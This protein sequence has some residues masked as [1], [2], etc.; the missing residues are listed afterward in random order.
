MALALP[1][2]H[3]THAGIWLAS[4]GGTE[5]ISVR[6]ASRGEAIARAAETPHIILNA[7][8]VGS[9]LGYPELWGLDLL[10]L[11]AFIHP[12]SFVV[13]T[14][15]GLRRA[16]GLG[17][18]ASEPTRP[19]LFQRDR[20][21]ACWRYSPTRLARTRRR[22]DERCDARTGC[23]WRWAPLLARAPRAAGARRAD[24]CSRA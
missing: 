2:L 22:V 4:G 12:A 13:P 18:P 19:L 3:A 10:E 8:L 21:Q 15:A 23:G 6:E 20:R 11:F 24:G 1:A 16:L 9:R 5:E 17:A 7:P 14:A